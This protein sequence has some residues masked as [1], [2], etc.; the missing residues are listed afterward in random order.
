MKKVTHLITLLFLLFAMAVTSR[1]QG[2]DYLENAVYTYNFVRYTSWPQ[3]KPVVDI[4]IVGTTP[5]EGELK[6]LLAR[7]VNSTIG[8][9]V[10]NIQPTEAKNMDVVIVARSSAD[11]LKEVCDH[12]AKAPILIISE[13]ENMSRTGAC[14][15]FFID[16]DNNFKTSYQLS[17][18]NCKA[19]GLLVSDQIIN[20]AALIK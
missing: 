13:K 5:L 3:K 16:E 17:I 4:G 11:Q 18:K 1:G 8:Y 10:R 7:K 15:S 6:K 2:F 12:T 9:V 20:N 14:I 19:R